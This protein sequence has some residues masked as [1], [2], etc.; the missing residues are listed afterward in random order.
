MSATIIK[1]IYNFYHNCFQKF[2]VMSERT[3]VGTG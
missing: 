1:V 2:I 3:P